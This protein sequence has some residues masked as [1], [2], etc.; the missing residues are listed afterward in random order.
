MLFYIDKMEGCFSAA[1]EE[2]ELKIQ[3]LLFKGSGIT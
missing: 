1:K 3:F 2:M